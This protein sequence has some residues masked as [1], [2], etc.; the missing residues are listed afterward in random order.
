M[1]LQAF[2]AIYEY[3]GYYFKSIDRI[4][5]SFFKVFLKI[6]IDILKGKNKTNKRDKQ[7][8]KKR[9]LSAEKLHFCQ[10]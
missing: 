10:I 7:E 5:N 1:Y 3:R 2:T 4:I 6:D 9:R 8:T